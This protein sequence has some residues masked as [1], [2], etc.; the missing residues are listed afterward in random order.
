M[1]ISATIKELEKHCSELRATELETIESMAHFKG[2]AREQVQVEIQKL[3]TTREQV[4]A[5]IKLQRQLA[6]ESDI[7]RLE[8]EVA[9]ATDFA[10]FKQAKD[11]LLRNRYVG[12]TLY[13]IPIDPA[14]KALCELWRIGNMPKYN[15]LMADAFATRSKQ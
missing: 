3:Q 4:L 2:T 8:K 13:G 15:K 11:S 1:S 7:A 9:T 5:E 14:D 12:Q 6:V 10:T